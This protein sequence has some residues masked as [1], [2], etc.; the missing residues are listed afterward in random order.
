MPAPAKACIA[1]AVLISLAGPSCRREQTPAAATS[2]A[3]IVQ[4]GAPGE[5]SRVLSAAT[6]G[7]PRP[8]D[9]TANAEFMQGMI[10]HHSQ[11]LQMVDILETRTTNATMK[12]LAK[13]ITISQTQEIRTMQAWLERRAQPAATAGMVTP[14][15]AMPGMLTETEMESLRVASG[16][17]FDRLFL[18]DMIRHHTGALTMVQQLFGSPGAG[19]DPEL[20]AFASGVDNDQRVEIARM[21]QLLREI[22]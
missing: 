17:T 8:P 18:T 10:R 20:F 14:M 16:A 13:K 21:Q 12:L 19:Q 4:P 22:K 3:T 6:V 5:E 11:A 15:P 9:R 2:T 1:G 7:T